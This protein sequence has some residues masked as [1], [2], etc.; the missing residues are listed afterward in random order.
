MSRQ[1]LV[2]VI[3]GFFLTIVVVFALIV[4]L[5]SFPGR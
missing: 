3:A 5:C 4:S 2:L 1:V